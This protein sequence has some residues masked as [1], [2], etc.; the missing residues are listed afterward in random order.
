[1]NLQLRFA[2]FDPEPGR[3]ERAAVALA[4]GAVIG[5][6]YWGASS[7]PDYVSDL[8]Q[9]WYATRAFLGGADPYSIVGPGRP[10]DIP[11]PLYYP[12]P[13]MLAFAPLALL[14]LEFAR[15]A[16]IAL[17]TGLLAYAI[18][19]DGWHRMPIF[20][21]GAYVHSLT[22]AQW[23]P[24]LTAAFVIP[25]LGPLL[26]LKPNI[27]LA[28]AATSP[29]RR[30]LA[31]GVLGGSVLLLAS[32][33]IDPTWPT[34]WL[35]HVR[36]APHFTPPVLLPGGF[37]VL[38]ALLRW[39]RPEARLLVAMACVPHTTLLYEALPV[40]LVPRTWKESFLLAALSIPA[41]VMQQQLDGRLD[42]TGPAWMA[43]F[44]EWATAVGTLLVILLYLPA[45][46]MVLRRSNEGELPA[47]AQ[48]LSPGLV[49]LR[50]RYAAGK[51][52]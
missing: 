23:S 21:S 19:H 26:L 14:P 45:T 49:S 38:L 4:I 48:A 29:A 6:F 11:F 24:L 17:S 22:S 34:R 15:T 41:F 35:A 13:A 30:L 52:R 5:A 8:D 44:T 9:V 42:L 33:A 25:W 40:M 10:Y 18:T 12:L 2:R 43:A 3:V 16:F 37:L 32:L 36:A 20:L 51:M 7:S 27:G 50:S 1:V 31:W 47:W 28:V 39:R 46:I